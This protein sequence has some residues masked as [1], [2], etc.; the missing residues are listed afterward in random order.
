MGRKLPPFAALRA[1]EAVARRGSLQSASEELAISASAV[2]HQVKAL[3]TFLGL[4]LFVRD[5]AGLRLTESGE[6]YLASVGDALDRLEAGTLRLL[7]DREQRG[8]TVHVLQSLAQLWLIPQLDDFVSANPDV[9]L[10]FVSRPE[11]LDFSGSNIDLAIVYAETPPREHIVEKLMDEVM[12]PVC[13]PG[14]LREHGLLERPADLLGHRLIGCD[15]VPDEWPDWLG[16]FQVE[17][18]KNAT[19]LM[20]DSRALALNAAAGGLGVAMN[21]RPTGDLMLRRGELVA[22]LGHEL[23]TGAAYWLTAPERSEL[24]P[25]AKQFRAWLATL[26]AG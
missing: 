6:A 18:P 24:L 17:A 15:H 14:Y 22:P 9:D 5:N 1:F 25:A 4:K 7:Q 19:G 16:A 23:P 8:L 3:E 11:E 2:S 10:A 12:T 13:S 20:F 26:C 21:R